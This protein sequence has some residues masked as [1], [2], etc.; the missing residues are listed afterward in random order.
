MKQRNKLAIFTTALTAALLVPSSSLAQRSCGS[1]LHLSQPHTTITLA[2]SVP[3]GPFALPGPSSGGH[4][5]VNVPAFCRVAGVIKPTADS[6]IHFEVWM[7]TRNWNGRF[8]G[9]GN[10]GF[11]GSINYGG[12][13]TALRPR[14]SLPK[15]MW[16]PCT[17]QAVLR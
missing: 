7:P 5:T 12:L 6:D 2:R 15:S 4:P 8:D 13:A 16:T 17:R 10:G 11:A 14:E 1:L 9:E 3:A